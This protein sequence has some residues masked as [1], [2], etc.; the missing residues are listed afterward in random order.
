[1]TMNRRE[2]M[3]ALSAMAALGGVAA[4]AQMSSEKV[5]SQSHVYAFD[6][7]PVK[8]NDNGSTSRAVLDGALPTGE[9]L[10]VHETMLLPGQSPHPPHRHRHSEMLLVREGTL[11]CNNDGK[12]ERIGPGGIFFAGSNVLHGVKNT[13]DVPT[14][15][16]VVAIGLER[17]VMPVSR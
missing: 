5:F 10:E 6:R 4:N 14:S 2:M 11:E 7:L 17:T 9:T 15:Y 1:M 3:A 8:K 12:L 13:G 16:F